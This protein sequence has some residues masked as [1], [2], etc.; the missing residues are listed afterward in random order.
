[1]KKIKI[2]R[3]QTIKSQKKKTLYKK[4]QKNFVKAM[5]NKFVSDMKKIF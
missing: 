3:L 2:V 4:V 5:I 1:M